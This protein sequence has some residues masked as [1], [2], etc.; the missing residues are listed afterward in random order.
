LGQF[1]LSKS[2]VSELTDPLTQEYEAF[3]TR[4]LSG[5]E[6]AY[7]FMDAVSEPLRRWG[8]KPGVFCV[9]AICVEG[10]KV[11]LTL[12][13]AN[14]E[15]SE[16]CPE[17]R[18]DLVRRGLQTPGTLTTEGAAGVTQALAALGPQARRVRGG[19]HKMQN[20][21][22]Q[23]PPQAWPEVKTLVAD[24]RGAPPGSEAERRRHLS[25]NRYQW[26]FPE[27][28]RCLLDD[29]AASL[30]HLYV[31]QRH[32]PYV[33]TSNLAERAFAEERRRT[34]VIPQL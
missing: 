9:G 6:I 4:D 19:C 5:Y 23:V 3:R 22:Q 14:R 11:L 32:Q 21:Q 16:S 18:R 30:N 15:S 29:A 8:S 26:D 7:L 13:T 12:S 20:L 24:R 31:P 17:V 10:H 28:C 25:V 1:I 33:R 27:A 2:T 34:K